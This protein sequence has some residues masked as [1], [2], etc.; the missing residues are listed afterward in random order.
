MSPDIQTLSGSYFNFLEPSPD[1]IVITDIAHALSNLCRF[2]GH[3]NSF[4]SVAQHSVLVSKLVPKKYQLAGLLH[5]AAE[6]YIGDIAS[7]LKQLLPEYKTIERRLEQVIFYKY[8][9]E[10]PLHSCIKEADQIAL[11]TEKR[12][13]MSQ[14]D[15]DYMYWNKDY[16][17]LQP[18][19]DKII[20]ESPTVAYENFINRFVEL[21]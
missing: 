14:H 13:V 17:H 10:F 16:L 2:T 3:C 21:L 6:A 11:L 15:H 20:P 1:T 8:D 12:D 5:D 4:Y 7:P 9:I 18:D 19:K